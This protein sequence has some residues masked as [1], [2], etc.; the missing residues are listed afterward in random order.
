MHHNTKYAVF[1]RS[2]SECYTSFDGEPELHWEDSLASQPTQPLV[3]YGLSSTSTPLTSHHQ[4]VQEFIPI[5]RMSTQWVPNYHIGLILFYSSPEIN[6][7]F[8]SLPCS[9]TSASIGFLGKFLNFLKGPVSMLRIVDIR[10]RFLDS[11]SSI[12]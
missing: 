4:T 12:L 9:N 10:W 5:T 6:V 11:D 7:Y 3:Y 2:I 1:Q 8:F